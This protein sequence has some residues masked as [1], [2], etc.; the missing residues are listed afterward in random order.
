MPENLGSVTFI[1]SNVMDFNQSTFDV[2]VILGLL[3][4]LTLEDQIKLMGKV[5]K[6]AVLVLDTQVHHSS[7][8]QHDAS[9]ARGF[10]TGNVVKKKNY[11]GVIFPEGDN[12]MASIENPTS[13]WHTPN[14]LRTLLREAGFVEAITVGEP[15][16]SKYGGREWIVARKAG[17]F[18]TI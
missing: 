1:Q 5:P 4:H 18:S 17:T 11:E 13:W 16:V 12:P 9:A 6:T 10:D 8:V 14:S 7:L 2:S 3:Y 15:Y